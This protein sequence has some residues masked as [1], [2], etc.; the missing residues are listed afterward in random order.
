MN[1]KETKI[2]TGI[3]LIIILALMLVHNT[4]PTTTPFFGIEPYYH[5]TKASQIID[6]SFEFKNKFSGQNQDNNGEPYDY[7]LAAFTVILG[8]Q[9][10]SNILPIITGLITLILVYNLL[11]KT[12]YKKNFRI[13]CLIFIGLSHAFIYNH[14][15]SQPFTIV[16]PCT[17]AALYFLLEK[18]YTKYF[19]VLFIIITALLEPFFMVILTV[20]AIMIMYLKKENLN[21]RLVLISFVSGLIT[22]IIRLVTLPYLGNKTILSGNFLVNNL[23]FFG[24][25]I[26][27]SLFAII[28]GAIGLAVSWKRKLDNS[29]IYIT[30]I[31]LII[32][33]IYIPSHKIFLNLII[34]FLATKGFIRLLDM[35]WELIVIRKLSSI[36]IIIGLIISASIYIDT[37][38]KHTPSK[39]LV[40]TLNILKSNSQENEIILAHPKVSDWTKYFAKRETSWPINESI[41][42]TRDEDRAINFLR[43]NNISYVLLNK[44]T[45]EIMINKDN[46]PGLNFVM[47]NSE[48]FRKIIDY[49]EN[50][51]WTVK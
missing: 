15:V 31:L 49:K 28:L 11:K 36:F 3:I 8:K 41:L 13:F 20:P 50:E 17:L 19:S 47:E 44:N 10:T 40:N 48:K 45:K 26:G 21:K 1:N 16:I 39:G 46:N 29:P 30:I 25:L 4:K 43:E 51:L 42:K 37:L 35:K 27:F 6:D 9:T 2:I 18:N 23:N 5:Q 32:S 38:N 7:I 14:L 34:C 24:S 12:N 33:S 22:V